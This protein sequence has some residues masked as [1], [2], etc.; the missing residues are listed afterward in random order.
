MEDQ[1]DLIE[2]AELRVTSLR[3]EAQRIHELHNKMQSLIANMNS[4]T[5]TRDLFVRT[6]PKPSIKLAIN[7]QGER[8]ATIH[9][10]GADF[11]E[12]AA[13]FIR[14]YDHAIQNAHEKIQ[15][16]ARDILQLEQP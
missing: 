15:K 2:N 16:L 6:D 8:V 7:T 12:A 9:P 11:D 1:D 14:V 4:W 13:L 5:E 3:G 10:T